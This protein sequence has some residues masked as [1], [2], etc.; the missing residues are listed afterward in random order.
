ML[1]AGIRLLEK[2]KKAKERRLEVT[3][4]DQA[5]NFSCFIGIEFLSQIANTRM[6]IRNVRTYICIIGERSERDTLTSVQNHNYIGKCGSTLYVGLS[7][8]VN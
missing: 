7:G 2:L 8:I 1:A 5:R 3:S 6:R 4:T